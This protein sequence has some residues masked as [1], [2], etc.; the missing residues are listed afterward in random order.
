MSEQEKRRDSRKS[1]LAKSRLFGAIGHVH[2]PFSLHSKDS[3]RTEAKKYNQSVQ[4]E[5]KTINLEAEMSKAEAG[6][7]AAR[8]IAHFQKS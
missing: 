4:G 1:D 8:L 5:F 6:V 2:N 7:M 3:R